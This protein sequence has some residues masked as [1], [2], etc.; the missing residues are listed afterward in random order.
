MRFLVAIIFF[1]QIY[2]QDF[3]NYPKIDLDNLNLNRKGK[4]VSKVKLPKRS[5]TG[6]VW[7]KD[8]NK[9]K[10]WFPQG[11]AGLKSKDRNFLAVTWYSK[12]KKQ[13]SK[14]V[15]ISIVDVTSMKKSVTYR[16]VLLIDGSGNPLRGNHAG[17]LAYLNGEF[18]VP[19]SSKDK[20]LVFPIAEMREI[21]EKDQK[22]FFDY[23]YLLIQKRDY[24]INIKPSFVS[25]D[26]SRKQFLVGNFKEKEKGYLA[27]FSDFSQK[28][29]LEGP[30][31]KKMQGAASHDG[32][33]WIACGYGRVDSNELYYAKYTPGSEKLPSFNKIQYRPG[34]EDL[35]IS[36]SG[37]LWLLTEFPN[38]IEYGFQNRVVFAIKQ[39]KIQ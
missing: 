22:L 31:K 30:F 17:G 10:D 37:N 25:Y 33:L 27:W 24:D 23:R 20:M 26:S 5:H 7:Q 39:S 32:N 34:L 19:D 12:L 3:N 6:F 8:D 29:K 4:V 21:P 11:I 1:T 28:P 13:K 36:K 9:T 14:G 35:H 38:R 15:R 2:A 18:Y 16:H